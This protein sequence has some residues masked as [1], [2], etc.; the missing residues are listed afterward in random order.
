ALIAELSGAPDVERFVGGHPLAGAEHAGVRHARA[1]LF[2]GAIWFLTPGASAARGA[3]IEALV[4][5]LGARPVPLDALA[6]DSLL[7][8]MSHLPH[9]L[10]NVLISAAAR[11]G[12]RELQLA[13]AGP[14]FRDATR[15]AGASTAIWADIYMANADLLADAV[16]EAIEELEQVR[17]LLREGDRAG[18]AAWNE[19]ARKRRERSRREAS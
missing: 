7:A 15:V 6:H 3:A 12:E 2:D 4:R 16:D 5:R 17:S 9:V 8:R 13:G 18:L 10:A 1:E 19:L 11:A 14:S